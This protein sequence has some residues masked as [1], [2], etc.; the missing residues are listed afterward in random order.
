MI[1]SF[2]NKI[3]P[4]SCV[5]L[6]GGIQSPLHF[7]RDM[8]KEEYLQNN[9]GGVVCVRCVCVREKER[10]RERQKERGRE[11]ETDRERERERERERIR[12]RES[13]A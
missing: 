8:E 1:Q 11:G 13:T 6:M 4:L 10:E 5:L 12:Y 9:G 2:E 3:S 7:K